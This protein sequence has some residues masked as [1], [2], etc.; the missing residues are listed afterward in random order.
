MSVITESLEE[1][2]FETT[3]E[4]DVMLKTAPW[5]ACS[6]GASTKTRGTGT[7]G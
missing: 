1:R 7:A 6:S 5:E 4:V 3:V 2:S